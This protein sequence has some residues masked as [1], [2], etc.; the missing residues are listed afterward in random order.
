MRPKR[1]KYEKVLFI[2]LVHLEIESVNA[3]L[4][5]KK[6]VMSI[7]SILSHDKLI[8]PM[9]WQSSLFPKI[10]IYAAKWDIRV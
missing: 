9:T 7:Y 6:A 2:L 3:E 4:S 5:I 1:R 10:G 8:L